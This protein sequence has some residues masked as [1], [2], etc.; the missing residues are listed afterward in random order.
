MNFGV[1]LHHIIRRV[2]MANPRL[3]PVYLEKV[4][5]ADAYMRLWVRLE[6]TPSV[7][8]LLP[9]KRPTDEQLVGFHL[10]LHMGYVDSVPYFCMSTETMEDIANTYM[11]GRH[12][13]MQPED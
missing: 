2:L 3:G 1:T 5:L 6:D 4:D 10:S 11:D 13:L 7:A 8:F 9:R 12:M